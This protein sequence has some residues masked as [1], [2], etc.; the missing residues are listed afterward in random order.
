MDDHCLLP[1][2]GALSGAD[3]L[4]HGQAVHAGHAGI[5]QDDVPRC[6]GQHVQYLFP[7]RGQPHGAA[8]LPQPHLEQI[9]A[10]GVILGHQHTQA[11]QGP[12]R[13]GR[14]VLFRRAQGA[15]LR[16]WA[17][18]HDLQ[19]HFQREGAALSGTGAHLHVPAHAAGDGAHDVQAQTGALLAA[20]GAAPPEAFKDRFFLSGLQPG[21]AVPDV[22]PQQEHAGGQA[23]STCLHAYAAPFREFD[24]IAHQIAQGLPQAEAVATDLPGQL[25]RQMQQQF[26]PLALRRRSVQI[27]AG[28]QTGGQVEGLAAQAHLPLLQRGMVGD[29]VHHLQQGPAGPAQIGQGRM[30]LLR[31]AVL[32]VEQVAHAQHGR[33]RGTHVVAEAPHESA[34]EAALLLGP[35]TP[36]GQVAGDAAHGQHPGQGQQA[37][38]QAQL[39]LLPR[40]LPDIAG[41]IHA[42]ADA[43]Q[44]V[45]F[46][47][48]LM[49]AQTA[50]LR[51]QRPEQAQTPLRQAVLPAEEDLSAL[52]GRG[53][54]PPLPVVGPVARPQG[55]LAHDG[56]T[57]AGLGEAFGHLAAHVGGV[58]EH[59]RA[60]VGGR[61]GP[62]LFRQPGI[63]LAVGAQGHID[64][65]VA[66][67][68][69]TGIHE[70]MGRGR[71]PGMAE[72][73]QVGLLAL[74]GMAVQAKGQGQPG[75]TGQHGQQPAPPVSGPAGGRD[76]HGVGHGSSVGPSGTPGCPDGGRRAGVV[77]FF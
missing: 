7:V 23:L 38:Q 20:G 58:H 60:P 72:L 46:P 43:A 35:Q 3:A 61:K 5:Q 8:L 69:V 21:P 26:Q 74:H 33:Q 29:V 47:V 32:A 76:T 2:R 6:G 25:R 24:G 70:L 19:T 16:S 17:A 10:R 48:P 56:Q 14:G 22:Q 9:A 27:R 13:R 66:R 18:L 75:G 51:G 40:Q 1:W 42:D 63:G 52:R 57:E 54:Y 50:L 45:P 11:V 36:Q 59:Q 31:P 67:V 73:Q 15:R 64:T 28:P 30:P 53:Q 62:V 68:P 34:L 65:T 55:G 12:G 77:I 71:Q 44:H 41:G 49:T 4:Q 37:V 39:P